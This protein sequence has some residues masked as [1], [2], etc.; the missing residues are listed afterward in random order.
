MIFQ[1]TLA[2]S[3]ETV[4]KIESRTRCLS[5]LAGWTQG[6][7]CLLGTTLCVHI[8]ALHYICLKMAS[9][10]HRQELVICTHHICCNFKPVS[11]CKLRQAGR[12]QPLQL[13]GHH[14]GPVAGHDCMKNV[15]GSGY[16]CM[17]S[18][19]IKP[20]LINNCFRKS[21]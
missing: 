21:T 19:M 20:S 4:K 3:K 5:R 1:S 18:T 17:K 15:C 9:C 14:G 16:I 6:R 12:S 10:T 2:C 8:G 13:P 11:Q 7:E